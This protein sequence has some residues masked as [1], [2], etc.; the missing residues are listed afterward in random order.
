MLYTLLTLLY[1]FCALLMILIVLMQKGKGSMGLGHMG[2]GQQALFGGSGGAD[3]FEKITWFLGAVL[4]IGALGLS[5][6]N[7]QS[8]IYT[9]PAAPTEQAPVQAPQE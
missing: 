2:G 7:S 8:H 6:L 5:M 1:G 4:V 3:L 9:A